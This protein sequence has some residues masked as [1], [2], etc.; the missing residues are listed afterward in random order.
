MSEVFVIGDVQG[1]YTQLRQL[2]DKIDAVS[3]QARLLFAGDLVNRGPESLDTLRYVRSLGDRAN[4]VL[5]NH[6]LHLLAV[7]HHVKKAHRSDTLDEILAASDSEDLLDWL[8]QR[9]LAINCGDRHLLVHA[10][11]FLDWNFDQCLALAHEIETTLRGNDFVALLRDMYGNQPDQWHDDLQ[12]IDRQRCI[13]NAFTRMRFCHQD[14]RMD[15]DLKEGSDQAPSHLLPW[16]VLPQRQTQSDTIIF[17]HWST[18]GLVIRPNLISLDTGCVWG[19]KL[20]AVRLS[21]RL[22]V[23]VDSPQHVVPF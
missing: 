7:A 17:G 5:G 15:F 4:S 22:L 6:D 16:F 18:L 1:C 13:I 21:D 9:P 11:I 3:P 19:G 23:Q 8:R 2:V 10:G 14:G 12:G 20:S